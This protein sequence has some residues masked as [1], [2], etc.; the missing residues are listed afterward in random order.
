MARGQDGVYAITLLCGSIQPDQ[1]IGFGVSEKKFSQNVVDYPQGDRDNYN[2]DPGPAIS[3]A[4]KSP[5]GKVLTNDKR[6]SVTREG[7]EIFPRKQQR[8]I[9]SRQCAITGTGNTTVTLNL[10]RNHGLNKIKSLSITNGGA[11][12]NNAVGVTTTIYAADLVIH[13]RNW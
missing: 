2:S 6:N 13:W 12:Y 5:L 11:G 9:C 8:C 1:N 4:R 10:T 3:H 7:E